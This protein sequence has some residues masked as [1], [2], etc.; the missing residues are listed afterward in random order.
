V[1]EHS[2][3]IAPFDGTRVLAVVVRAGAAIREFAEVGA[4]HLTTQA[5]K[6]LFTSKAAIARQHPAA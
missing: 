6:V 1:V 5:V 2:G 3:A 4:G